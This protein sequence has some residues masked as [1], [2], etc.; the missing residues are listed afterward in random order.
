MV[1][2]LKLAS[3]LPAFCSNFPVSTSNGAAG[4]SVLVIL[5]FSFG[6]QHFIMSILLTGLRGFAGVPSSRD[7]Q[8][9]MA[10]GLPS[11]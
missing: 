5:K 2:R 8:V 6:F 11:R 7:V 4:N 1:T 9:M 10:H 3:Y